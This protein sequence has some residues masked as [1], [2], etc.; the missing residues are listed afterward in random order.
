VKQAN[1]PWGSRCRLSGWLSQRSND[2]VRERPPVSL[3]TPTHPYRPGDAA[4]VKEWNVQ[5]LKPHWRGPFIVMYSTPT[6]VKVAETAP[7]IHYSRVK[8]A[9][10]E[11]ECIPDPALP[12]TSTL[13]NFGALPQQDSTPQD[14]M[15]DHEQ[16][17]YSSTLVTFG[18]W[19]M[20]TRHK[21]KSAT[22]RWDR[23]TVFYVSYFMVMH[24][25]PICVCCWTSHPKLC[26][27]SGR[28]HPCRLD[29]QWKVF[30]SSHVPL[31]GRMH[32]YSFLLLMWFPLV[33]PEPSSCD[34]C[35]STTWAG[36]VVARP[37]LFRTYYSCA[38]TVIRS[39]TYKRTTY[40]V[41][42]H[43][44]QHV[45]FNP[46]YSPREQWLEIRSICNSGDL[47]SHT[48]VFNPDKP[49]SMLFD[50]CAAIDKGG[51]GGVGWGCVGLAW[52]RAYPSSIW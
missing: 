16:W 35:M 8:P 7:W 19:L 18:G 2:R 32:N 25:H 9:S 47:V 28:N 10:L 38:G 12:C 44:N 26:R 21:V 37:L 46:T 24:C 41:C 49:V 3:K 23:Q 31:L 42:A 48:L 6:A 27:R 39:C 5:P 17:D 50:A 34:L 1:S 15:G 51:C 40:L 30:I 11:W 45:C 4:W 36:R 33:L 20:Y 13:Q 22:V 29:P 43:S 52:E 14:T